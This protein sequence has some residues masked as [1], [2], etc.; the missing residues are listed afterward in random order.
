MRIRVKTCWHGLAA[1]ALSAAM[2]VPAL[3]QSEAAPPEPTRSC[4]FISDWTG[5][6]RAP[7]PEVIYLRIKRH[8]IWRVDLSTRA[9]E[10]QWADRSLVT[11]VNGGNTICSALDLNLSVTDGSGFR[12]PLIIKALTKLTP[13]EAAALPEKDRP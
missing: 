7:S 5:G 12:T 6:W 8:D 4:F 13:D 2:A 3:A 11:T 10:L 9:P 1:L